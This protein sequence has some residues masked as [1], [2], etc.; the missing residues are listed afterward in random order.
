MIK[1]VSRQILEITDTGNP[2]FERAF[3][4][5]SPPFTDRP[6]DSLQREALRVLQ[7]QKGYS[8][9]RRARRW[10]RC[11]QA[12]LLLLGG[13]LGVVVERVMLTLFG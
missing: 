2:Y 6:D 5:V 4:V 3:L 1:G 8:G 9:L 12:A 7:S 11:G 10:R 13:M